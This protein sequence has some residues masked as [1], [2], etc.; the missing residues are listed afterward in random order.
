MLLSNKKKWMVDT[1][2]TMLKSQKPLGPLKEVRKMN[3]YC[4]NLTI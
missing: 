2:N 4:I 3:T 1:Y